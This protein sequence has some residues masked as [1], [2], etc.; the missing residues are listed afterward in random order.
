M[1]ERFAA[2]LAR[3]RRPAY[4]T[5]ICGHRGAP[6]AAPENTL[7]GFRAAVDLRCECVELDVYLTKDEEVVVIHD[8]K[9]GR[10]TDRGGLVGRLTAAELREADAGGW[11]GDGFAGERIPTLR[12]TLE[13]LRGRAVPLIEVKEKASKVKALVPRLAATIRE[14]GAEESCVT[15]WREEPAALALKA[16]LPGCLHSMIAFTY[17][18]ARRAIRAGLDGIV[19]Y[20]RVATARMVADLQAGGLF[21]VPWTVNRPKDME[22][23]IDAGADAVI[24]DFPDVLH[25]MLAWREVEEARKTRVAE[26]QPASKD[27]AAA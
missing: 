9:L 27:A 19:P 23:F 20:F 5:A 22:Y 24:T 17:R 6:A 12:E 15:I 14:A 18:R 4:S 13:L 7:S 16:E 1:T 21:C 8:A 10:T 2:M 26:P 11:F 25:E 3:A